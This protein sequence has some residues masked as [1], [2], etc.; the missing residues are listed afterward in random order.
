MKSVGQEWNVKCSVKQR[1]GEGQ[2]GYMWH[3]LLGSPP[4]PPRVRLGL[5]PSEPCTPGSGFLLLGTAAQVCWAAGKLL[6]CSRACWLRYEKLFV[7]FPG[8]DHKWPD[9]LPSLGNS[10]SGPLGLDHPCNPIWITRNL[11]CWSRFQHMYGGECEIWHMSKTVNQRRLLLQPISVYLRLRWM[12]HTARQL[13]EKKK[14]KEYVSKME[15][16]SSGEF[17]WSDGANTQIKH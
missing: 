1:L 5:Q 4:P 13:G 12:E 6:P 3:L 7:G 14:W 9:H 11:Y 8:S 15:H 10:V 2:V 17:P 16:V